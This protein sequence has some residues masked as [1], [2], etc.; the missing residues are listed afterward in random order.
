[1][2]PKLASRD[3]DR[4]GVYSFDSHTLRFYHLANE[5]AMAV[6]PVM[7]AA[8]GAVAAHLRRALPRIIFAKYPVSPLW[9]ENA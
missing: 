4:E 2:T 5:A 7:A 8:A 9:G 3:E 1:L 6:Y